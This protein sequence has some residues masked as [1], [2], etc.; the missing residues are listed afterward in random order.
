MK[1]ISRTGF[2]MK[3]QLALDMLSTQEALNYWLK[4]QNNYY[5]YLIAGLA[6]LH[7]A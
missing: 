5:R 1:Y 2:K 3:L 6:N 7:L 4:R